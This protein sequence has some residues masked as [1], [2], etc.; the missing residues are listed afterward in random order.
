MQV[1]LPFQLKEIVQGWQNNLW[2]Q[3]CID[4]NN[5]TTQHFSWTQNDTFCLLHINLFCKTIPPVLT[6]L[7]PPH[8]QILCNLNV[9]VR[10]QC[11]DNKS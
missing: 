2:C 1:H 10:V 5:A 3:Y 11:K 9:A 4:Y 6:L 8:R 7:P